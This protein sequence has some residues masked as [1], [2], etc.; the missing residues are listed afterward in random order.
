[1]EDVPESIRIAVGSLSGLPGAVVESSPE[2]VEAESSWALRLRLTS[3]H[4]S[5]FVP[6]ETKWVALV[7]ASYPAGGIRIYPDQ[8]DGLIH[9]FPHQDR[10]VLP[11][12]KHATWRT[13]KPCL[14]SPSQRLGRIA[15]GPEPK[16]DMEQRLRWHVQRCLGWLHVA[17]DEQLMVSGEPFEVPQCPAELLDTRFRVV[18][19]EGHDTWPSWKERGGQYGEVRWGVMPGFEKTIVAEK[20]LDARGEVIRVCRRSQSSAAEPWVG[21]WWLWP[22]PI[23]LPPWH[24][25]GTWAELRRAG[26]G[27]KVN[28]DAFIHWIAHRAGGKESVIVLLGYPVPKLWNGAPVEV[29]WQAI[30]P[31]HVPATLRPL[32]GFR[33]NAVGR[34]E[35]LRR[36]IFVGTKELSHLKTSNWHPDRL[37]ARGRFP[38]NVR[39]SS[40]AVIGAGALGSAV[41]EILARGGVAHILIVDHDDL[42]PGNL[43]RHTLVG[44]DLGRNKATATAARLQGAAPMSTISAHAAPLPCGDSLHKLLDQIDIVLDCKAEDEVLRRLGEAWWTIP[45][46]FLSASLGFAAKRLF[47]FGTQACAF[48][49]EEF[50]AAVNPWLADERSQWSKAGETL[51]GAGCW[52]PLF[53]ARCDDVWLGALATVKYLESMVQGN[54]AGGLRVL[55]QS[56]DEGIAGYRVVETVAPSIDAS[57]A[58]EGGAP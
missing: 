54:W 31:P 51:E 6:E 16:G 53:P 14:D 37:Q 24:T 3:G 11:S 23:V 40:I 15:G 44:A 36:D 49:F 58:D 42:E 12:A 2:F 21:Y 35:R 34:K 43:V 33:R 55:E 7:D 52:S 1:M 57:V 47:L 46:H 19:D 25:P 27:M 9:T 39:E 38:S 18:H 17:G 26:S 50:A 32:K 56:T 29:H 4:P 22:S 5:D 28:V 8:Q 13:G 30:L 20:F 41:A 48:P 45:R 10:N